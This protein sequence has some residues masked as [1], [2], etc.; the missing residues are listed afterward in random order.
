MNRVPVIFDCDTGLDDSL[1]LFIAVN[2]PRINVLCVT[3]SFGNTELEH[4][5]L[6]TLNAL[7]TLGHTDIPVA[8]GAKSG[9]VKPLMTSPQIHGTSGIGM[10][11]YPG[12]HFEAFAGEPAWDLTYDLLMKSDRKVVYFALGPCTN[13]ATTLRKYPEVRD[14]LEKVIF[15]GGTLREAAATQCASV[16]VYH[17]PEACRYVINSGVP[18]YMCTHLMT[19]RVRITRKQIDENLKNG[20]GVLKTAWH[21]LSDYFDNCNRFGENENDSLALHDPAT[22]LYLI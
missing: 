5:T 14:K 1:A 8:A 22:V 7:A 15:M 21:F 16:N 10:Y 17:D 3:S 12:D 13:L 9:W 11:V 4:A 6:N 20:N 18:F 19:N 2:D